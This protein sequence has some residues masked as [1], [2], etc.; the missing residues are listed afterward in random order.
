MNQSQLL[1][2]LKTFLGFQTFSL[3]SAMRVVC[4]CINKDRLRGKWELG[5]RLLQSLY[6]EKLSTQAVNKKVN[7]LIKRRQTKN[8][9]KK[10]PKLIHHETTSNQVCKPGLQKD[11]LEVKKQVTLKTRCTFTVLYMFSPLARHKALWCKQV[12]QVNFK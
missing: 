5:Q 8:T 4:I 9:A 10:P 11:H 12:S 7:G 6:T 2:L 1:S 3:H